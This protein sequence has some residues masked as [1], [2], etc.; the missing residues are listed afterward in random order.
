MRAEIKSIAGKIQPLDEEEV[1]HIAF[2]KEWID[3]GAEIFRIEK[4]A[5]TECMS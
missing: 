1:N 3:S 4:P 5:T 2:V